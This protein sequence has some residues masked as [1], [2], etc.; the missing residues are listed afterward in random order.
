MIQS[1]Y[2]FGGLLSEDPDEHIQRFMEVCNTQKYNG[3]PSKALRLML[4]PF[5][6]TG[7]A[8]AWLNSLPRDS[9]TSWEE[10]MSKFLN[11]FFHPSKASKFGENIISFA[12]LD[13]ETIYEA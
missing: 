7:K 4:F 11:K 10:H 12:Q 8:R 13:N 1:S 6:L 9:I 5:S 2:S 3:V